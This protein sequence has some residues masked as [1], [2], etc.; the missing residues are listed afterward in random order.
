MA[1]GPDVARS[2]FFSGTPLDTLIFISF[3]SG[4]FN[5][6]YTYAPFRKVWVQIA[7]TILHV[8]RATIFPAENR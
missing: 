5:L 4:V 1:R 8:R 3:N 6:F 7:A 2:R